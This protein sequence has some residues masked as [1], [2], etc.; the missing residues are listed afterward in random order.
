MSGKA[1]SEAPDGRF[2][3]WPVGVHELTPQADN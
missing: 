2:A 3:Q 1:L